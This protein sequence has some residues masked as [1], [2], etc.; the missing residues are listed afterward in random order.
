MLTVER[1]T[2]SNQV[3]GGRDPTGINLTAG[4]NDWLASVQVFSG[5]D[6][7]AFAPQIDGLAYFASLD[8]TPEGKWS[9]RADATLNHLSTRD[10]TFFTYDWAGSLNATFDAEPFGFLGTFALGDNGEQAA[11]QGGMF[12]GIVLMPWFW[13][14]PEKTQAV[15]QYGHS[16]ASEAQGIRANSRYL[17]GSQF[18]ADVNSGRGDSLDTCY[19]GLNQYLCGNNLKLMAGIEYADLNTPVGKTDSFTYNF[20]ARFFF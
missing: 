13:I 4:K 1:S 6:R 9:Y 8:Y 17:A 12:F 3:F 5:I 2:I 7:E 11:G 16:G 20:A 18:H 14:V 19:L 10:Q 15:F